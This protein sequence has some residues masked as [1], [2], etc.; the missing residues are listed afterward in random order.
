MDVGKNT[1][2]LIAGAF[3]L[4]AGVLLLRI[5]PVW[6]ALRTKQGENIVNYISKLVGGITA[7]VGVI[8]GVN[9][10]VD[11]QPVFENYVTTAAQSKNSPVVV[12]DTVVIRDTVYVSPNSFGNGH[13]SNFDEYKRKAERDFADYAKAE[14]EKSAS[15]VNQKEAD[16]KAYVEANNKQFEE[17]LK[18]R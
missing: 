3:I 10:V 5:K 11:V 6:D 4:L 8:I 16:F 13:G 9:L 7:I 17:F 1:I 15:Y 18:N 2:I 14:Q 12:R